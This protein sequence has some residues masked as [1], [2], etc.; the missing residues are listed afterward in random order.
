MYY[1]KLQTNFSFLPKLNLLAPRSKDKK[2]FF[3]TENDNKHLYEI[4]LSLRLDKP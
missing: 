2:K 4:F 3:N 1:M